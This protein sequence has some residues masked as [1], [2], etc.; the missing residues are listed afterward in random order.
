MS[1]RKDKRLKPTD[2]PEK[3]IAELAAS[4]KIDEATALDLIMFMYEESRHG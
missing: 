3:A 2:V 4:L 1:K